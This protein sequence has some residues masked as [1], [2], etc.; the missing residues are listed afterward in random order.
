MKCKCVYLLTQI[1]SFFHFS[2][3][4]IFDKINVQARW[5]IKKMFLFQVNVS[6]TTTTKMQFRGLDW[7]DTDSRSLVVFLS[8]FLFFFTKP[9][10]FW[11]ILPSKTWN[12]WQINC[13]GWNYVKSAEK[14]LPS[15]RKWRERFLQEM[16][17]LIKRWFIR[18]RISAVFTFGWGLEYFNQKLTSFN[19]L[20][21]LAGPLRWYAK[22]ENFVFVQGVNFN[23]SIR[24]ETSIQ[25]TC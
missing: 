20:S 6:L 16:A 5:L 23:R 10:C 8:Q 1:F 15:A 9:G 17:F 19:N 21:A 24:W 2:R 25:K 3:T 7:A 14:I 13:F 12:L 11:T 18:N 22:N 4:F